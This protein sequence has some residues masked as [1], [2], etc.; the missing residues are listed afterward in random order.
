MTWTNR[1]SIVPA[2]YIPLAQGLSAG[3]SGIA[4]SGMWTTQ[5]EAI[6]SPG[7]VTHGISNGCM[8]Q[9]FAD[10]LPL[11]VLD[12]K[13]GKFTRVNPGQAST[14]YAALQALPN[15]PAVTLAT[16]QALLAA[17]TVTEANWGATLAALG[18]QMK[19]VP[20]P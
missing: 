17:V 4:G 20:L 5:L 6:A 11:D 14:I 7:T 2:A 19:Q 13:T 3:L 18:L 12:P 8:E 1:C 9:Q 16:L 10:L 15:P